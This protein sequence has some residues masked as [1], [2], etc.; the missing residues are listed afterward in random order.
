MQDESFCFIVAPPDA[1]QRLDRWLS[2]QLTD[3]SRA[4]VQELIAQGLVRYNGQECRAKDQVKPGA[5][6]Q[7]QVPALVPLNLEA[8]AMD[9]KVVFEDEHLLVLDKPVGLVVHPAPGHSVGTLVHGLLAH[10]PDLSGING[11]ERPGI[12]HRLDKDTSGLMVVAKHDRAHQ[13]LQ[14]QIQQ[15]TA[16]R[17]YLGV[18][19][20]SPRAEEG[21]VDAPIGRHPVHRQRMAVVPH[22]R[23]AR[24]HW[25]VLERLGHFSLLHF[26]LETGRTHQIRV[27][28]LHLGHPIAGDP[29]Y[30]QGKT[31]IKLTGQALHAYRLS[32]VHPITGH[33][34]CFQTPPPAQFQKL[35]RVLGSH[36]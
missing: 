36:K 17:E 34:L 21:L 22:G 9:L 15:K 6:V 7:V 5:E 18:V 13:S 28:A 10:C 23:D 20:G 8:E 12:V 29:L 27:H 35:L 11:V 19:H 16:Q 31:P 26:R 2:M 3:F 25:Q 1:G 33:P 32:F 4:R 30:S 24:T 14:T